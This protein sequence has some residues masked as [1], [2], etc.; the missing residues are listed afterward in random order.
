MQEKWR[1][2]VL[3]LTIAS[4]I[5]MLMTNYGLWD[6]VGMTNEFFTNFVNVV[7]LAFTILGIVN[8]PNDG[9]QW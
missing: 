1:S 9:E 5:A 8:N 2:K 4:A 6:A 3:W 7:L